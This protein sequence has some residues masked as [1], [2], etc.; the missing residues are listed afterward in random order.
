MARKVKLRYFSDIKTQKELREV[1]RELELREWYA[2]EKFIDNASDTFSMDNLLSIVAPPG[3]AADRVVGGIGTGIAT[4]RGIMNAVQ[5][6]RGRR[7][8][9]GC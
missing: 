2:G 9:C 6:F 4:V 3:S 7:R 1:R 5:M 8:G